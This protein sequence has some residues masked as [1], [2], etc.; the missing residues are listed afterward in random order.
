MGRVRDNLSLLLTCFVRGE[1]HGSHCCCFALGA[2]VAS[3]SLASVVIVS[4]SVDTFANGTVGK[5]GSTSGLITDDPAAL[6]GTSGTIRRTSSVAGGPVPPGD[7]PTL[8]G[9][10]ASFVANALAVEEFVSDANGTLVRQ[11][12]SVS[13]SFAN[14]DGGSAGANAQALT[15]TT[16]SVSVNTPYTLTGTAAFDN[17]DVSGSVRLNNAIG[18]AI[19]SVFVAQNGSFSFSGTL[20]PSTYSLN[21]N[22]NVTATAGAAGVPLVGVFAEQGNYEVILVLGQT[23]CGDV[24]FN[25][26]GLFPDDADL[27]AFLSVLAGGNCS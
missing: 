6:S 25:N 19:R 26:D 12:A 27:V 9:T 18:I 23:P 16:F 4:G 24:D 1:G 11:S 13:N 8:P 14:L 10:S 7:L 15:R 22:C 17:E 21:S 3:S 5:L 2:C 20:T